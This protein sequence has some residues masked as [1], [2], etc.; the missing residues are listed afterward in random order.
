M[1][2]ETYNTLE[3]IQKRRDQL[4]EDIE[5]QGDLIADMWHEVFRKPD[6]ST[7]GEYIGSLIANSITAI[8]AF[9]LVRKLMRSYSGVFDFFGKRKS[10]KSKHR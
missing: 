2:T 9:L 3:E 6:E 7:K 1:Q 4:S 8:D 10:K 5:Q